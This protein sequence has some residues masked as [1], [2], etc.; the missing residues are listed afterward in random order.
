MFSRRAR[1]A[2]REPPIALRCNRWFWSRPLR[3]AGFHPGLAPISNT[4]PG[5]KRHGRKCTNL[6][7]ALRVKGYDKSVLCGAEVMALNKSSPSRGPSVAHTPPAHANRSQLSLANFE[8]KSQA[9]RRRKCWQMVLVEGR[10]ENRVDKAGWRDI[11]CTPAFCPEYEWTKGFGGASRIANRGFSRAVYWA[12]FQR[13]VVH[14][15]R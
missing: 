13:R 6:P 1:V 4:I 7:R 15:K 9:P 11:R 2:G 12:I 5:S 14:L 8:G 3:S 10:R